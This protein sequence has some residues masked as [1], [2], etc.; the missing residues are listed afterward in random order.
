MKRIFPIFIILLISSA[1][2]QA[3]APP[4][5]VNGIAAKVNEEI[6]TYQQVRKLLNPTLQSLAQRLSPEALEREALK[7]QKEAID[8]L[9]EHELILHDYQAAGYFLPESVVEEHIQRQIH[10][11]Y[12]DRK[13]LAKTLRAQGSNYEKFKE[14]ERE[15]IIVQQMRHI[16]VSSDIIV[17][18]QKIREYYETH[19]GDFEREERVKLRMILLNQPEGAAPDRA[20]RMAREIL[21]KLNDGAEFEEM[22][23]VYSEGSQ[24]AKGGDWGWVEKSVLRKDLADV[25]FTLKKGEISGVIAT[26]EAAFIMK[27]DN[28]EGKGAKPLT[29]ISEEIEKDLLAREKGRIY[30]QYVNRLKDRQY[31]AYF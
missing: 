16:K 27:V 5:V 17:S 8:D 31:V 18:P 21:L 14:Q 30:Q 22:A 26:P 10:E 23:K 9:V 28:V 13:T 6:I 20:A 1:A 19:Q 25:A 29:E 2:V 15:Q 7:L 4:T 11:R 12:G 24:A 3:A